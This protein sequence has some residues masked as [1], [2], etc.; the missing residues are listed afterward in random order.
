MGLWTLSHPVIR[1][2]SV[3]AGFVALSVVMGFSFA[4]L[5]Q[6]GLVFTLRPLHRR[7]L[8]RRP[9]TRAP[10]PFPSPWAC[11]SPLSI[12]VGFFAVSSVAAELCIILHLLS[13][14]SSIERTPSSSLTCPEAVVPPT[15]PEAVV[16][17][18][19]PEAVVPLTCPSAVDLSEGRR[20][21]RRPSTCPKAVDLSEGRR[22]VRRCRLPVRRSLCRLPARRAS[23]C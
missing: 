19:C 3:D 15:C 9:L 1:L 14:R 12:D 22:P 23:C 7:G 8:V 10:S 18:T 21:V 2:P 20:P 17:P 4:P 16:P 5:H 6:H 13:V 11:L